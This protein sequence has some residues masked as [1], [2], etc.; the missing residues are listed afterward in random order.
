MFIGIKLPNS[1]EVK[2]LGV[3][4]D[5]KLKFQYVLKTVQKLG[6]LNRISFFLD[7]EKKTCIQYGHKVFCPLIWMFSLRKTNNL[8]NKIHERS[9]RTVYNDRKHE[10]F[11]LQVF[12]FHVF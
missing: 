7:P 9:L 2:V 12:L 8:I 10:Y 1:C 6:F 5:N 3:I 4:I 11:H